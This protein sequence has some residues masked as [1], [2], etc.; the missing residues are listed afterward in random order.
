MDPDTLTVRKANGHAPANDPFW[1]GRT[2]VE[3]NIITREQFASARQHWIQA[4]LQGSFA[5]VLEELGLGNPQYLAHLIARHH[6]LPEAEL[7]A[8]TVQPN[9]TRL[10]ARDI[11]R[12]RCILPFQ[13]A[14]HI[15]HVAIAEPESYSAH[16]AR[17]DFPD[18]NV[19]LHVAPR[20]DIV[21][22]IEEAWRPESVPASA[23]DLFE[24]LLREALTEQATDL[25]LEPRDNALDVRRRIDGRLIHHCFIEESL[26]EYVIQ[27]A[28]IAGRMDISERR[29]PQDGQGS[30]QVGSRLYN[31]RYS[32]IPAVN[33][34]SVVVRIIDEFAGLRSFEEIGL[35]P[36]DIVRVQRFLNE[37][38]GLICATGP[39]GAGKTTLLYSMLGNLPDINE[40]KI[41]TLEEPVELRNPRFFLQLGVDERI[42]RTF[43]ELL[44]RVLR[45]DPD[46]IMVGEIRDKETAEITLRASLTGHLCFSTVHTRSGLGT[47]ERL[48]DLGL[49]PLMLASA[50]KGVIGQR[51]VRRPC[52]HCRKPHPRRE[53][54]QARFKELLEAEGIGPDRLQFCLATPGRDCPVCHGRGHRG[55]I[56]IIEVFPLAGLETLIAS[57]AAP[58]E[59]LAAVRHRGYRTLFEDG[60]R[61]AALGLTTMEEVFAALAEPAD[62]PASTPPATPIVQAA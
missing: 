31:L 39:T 6:G 48:S 45:H 7:S 49:D 26:R 44:R 42:G 3:E 62:E 54:Y 40:T 27:A 43:G 47:I 24:R 10:L 11:A 4:N 33:G 15:L 1:L 41:I 34:E 55:R 12:R 52:P 30:L 32:C 23:T 37:P 61:K 2:L 19:R 29:L 51:L 13:E 17:Q 18:R 16:H 46:V 21:A 20:R 59:L 58:S 25:H 5:A 9:A 22:M 28:K 56:A 53:T 8:R 35:F 38:D 36:A 60:V 50:L 57:G 14:E